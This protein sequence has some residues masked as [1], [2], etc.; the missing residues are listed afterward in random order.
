VYHWYN[1]HIQQFINPSVGISYLLDPTSIG[2][3]AVPK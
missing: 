3:I 2:T 1:Q